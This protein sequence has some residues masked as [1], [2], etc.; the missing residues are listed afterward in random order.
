VS[1]SLL[2]CGGFRAGDRVRVKGVEIIGRIRKFEMRAEEVKGLVMW[3]MVVSETPRIGA[4]WSKI[5]ELEHA[6]DAVTRLGRLA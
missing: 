5:A 6:S 4:V 1:F 2:F 3:A